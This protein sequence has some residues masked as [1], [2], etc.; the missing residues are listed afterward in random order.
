MHL[1]SIQ[2]YLCNFQLKIDNFQ[3][4][5]DIVDIIQHLNHVI[6]SL[7]FN[8]MLMSHIFDKDDEIICFVIQYSSIQ[9]F[10]NVD[11]DHFKIKR[12]LLYILFFDV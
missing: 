1:N 9:L 10:L 11:L 3:F 5:V 2:C 4:N 8:V 6:V 12:S 7:D